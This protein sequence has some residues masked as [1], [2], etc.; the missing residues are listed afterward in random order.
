M[1][2]GKKVFTPEGDF[3][4]TI[5]RV[6][7]NEFGVHTAVIE[8]IYP[9][10]PQFEV[11]MS[12]LKPEKK[13]LEEGEED[14]YI[15]K[16]VPIKLKLI[17]EEKKKPPMAAPTAEVAQPKIKLTAAKYE[18]TGERPL[19]KMITEAILKRREKSQKTTSDEE[20]KV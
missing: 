11:F 3:V 4:G 2:E 15:L 6:Y 16:Y 9:E 13:K 18:T 14:V 19:L 10:F 20:K 5:K 8:T 1:P 7:I 17:L 12:Q